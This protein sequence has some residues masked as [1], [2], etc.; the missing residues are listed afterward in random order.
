M[1]RVTA[2][3]YTL[4]IPSNGVAV[5]YEADKGG[6]DRQ[7]PGGAGY[8]DALIQFAGEVT[9][10]RAM[11]DELSSQPPQDIGLDEPITEEWLKESGFRWSHL[12]R[13]DSKHWLLWLGDAVRERE[14][15][16][17][18]SYENIGIEI[19]ANRNDPKWF[20]WFRSHAGGLYGR[21]LHVRHVR[22]KLDVVRIVEAVTGYPWTPEYHVGGSARGPLGYKNMLDYAKRKDVELLVEPNRVWHDIER[23]PYRAGA[24]APTLREL[25]DRQAGKIP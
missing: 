22:L 15:F 25:V 21:F 24:C 20:C 5:L 1:T 12:D 6:N 14:G 19:A 13:Q 11:V 16:C 9:R 18:T 8:L 4:E 7:L 2:G 3:P 10:L 23:D 17:F